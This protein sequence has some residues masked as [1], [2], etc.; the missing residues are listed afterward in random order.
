[1]FTMLSSASFGITRPSVW[2]S[3]GETELT[4]TRRGPSSLASAAA[5]ASLGPGPA[6]WPF[7]I[8]GQQRSIAVRPRLATT[9]FEL[10]VRN[11]VAQPSV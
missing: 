10:A 3:P 9:S 11:G 7:V 8:A 1:M 2:V 5:N 6:E 4:V